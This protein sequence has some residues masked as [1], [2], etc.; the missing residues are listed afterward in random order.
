MKNGMTNEWKT[1]EPEFKQHMDAWTRCENVKDELKK[2]LYVYDDKQIH[3]ENSA[4]L[5]TFNPFD[6]VH[7]N[8]T[9]LGV[10]PRKKFL[11]LLSHSSFSSQ[12]SHIRITIIL[13]WTTN[14]F[15]MKDVNLEMIFPYFLKS[16]ANL[17]SFVRLP[18]PSCMYGI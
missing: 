17:M 4:F 7:F 18:L 10:T 3:C 8:Q 12:L 5:T 1:Y 16:Q 14:A 13:S 2:F 11:Y 15:C 6:F 9:L